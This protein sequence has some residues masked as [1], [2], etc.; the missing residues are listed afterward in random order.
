MA[1][2]TSFNATVIVAS[3]TLTDHCSKVTVNDGQES[4]E[5]RVF[6]KTY[7][8]NRGGLATPS[9]ALTFY[10]D[11]AASSV[12]AILSA[13]IGMSTSAGVGDVYV[14]YANGIQSTTNPT[15]YMDGVIDGDLLVMD[16]G[17][18]EVPELTVTFKPYSTFSIFTSAS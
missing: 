6:G 5:L 3:T 18:G 15:Y 4:K 12:R 11:Q 9:I 14:R 1:I 17:A 8:I 10:N 13:M 7:P 16:D 2:V